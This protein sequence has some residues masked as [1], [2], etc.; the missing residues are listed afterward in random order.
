MKSFRLNGELK[1]KLN[2]V[3]DITGEDQSE[4]FRRAIDREC[5]RLLQNSLDE[6]LDDI[7]GSINAGGGR[8][9]KTGEQFE[10]LLSGPENT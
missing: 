6:S 8:A 10:E 4:L 2:V 1:E 7:V 5:D 3:L 9:E